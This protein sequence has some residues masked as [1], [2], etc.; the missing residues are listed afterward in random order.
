MSL[1]GA[2]VSS[3]CAN[4][5]VVTNVAAQEMQA[6]GSTDKITHR[7]RDEDLQA[8]RI[9]GA[10]EYPNSNNL[11]ILLTAGHEKVL[12]ISRD[13]PALGDQMEFSSLDSRTPNEVL[14]ELLVQP[15]NF[16][17]AMELEDVEDRIDTATY[18]LD[19]I[20]IRFTGTP[21]NH[22]EST[23]DFEDLIP[24]V[25]DAD[26]CSGVRDYLYELPYGPHI[27]PSTH[28]R[29]SLVPQGSSDRWQP[30]G[31][32]ILPEEKVLR[33]PHLQSVQDCEY[34]IISDGNH[35]LFWSSPA[36]SSNQLSRWSLPNWTIER[37]VTSLHREE[38]ARR[39]LASTSTELRGFWRQNKLY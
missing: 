9:G 39:Q 17:Q 27:C 36:Q 37:P 33:S 2:G 32:Q 19:D 5:E 8:Q 28:H 25:S 20:D 7:K 3:P 22:R 21:G 31:I 18:D 29:K 30:S 35:P 26:D 11:E 23:E 13:N 1:P 4:P 14:M 16:S 10:R 34:G 15:G 38:P 24:L 12:N 6:A